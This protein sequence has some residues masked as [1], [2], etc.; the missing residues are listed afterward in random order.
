MF[1]P[2]LT[3]V[4]L[5]HTS[6]GDTDAR[7]QYCRAALNEGSSDVIL[8]IWRLTILPSDTPELQTALTRTSQRGDDDLNHLFIPDVTLRF[9]GK[10]PLHSTSGAAGITVADS[11]FQIHRRPAPKTGF[12]LLRPLAGPIRHNSFSTRHLPFHRS[13]GIGRV[14]V[15]WPCWLGNVCVLCCSCLSVS[16]VPHDLTLQPSFNAPH[17]TGRADCPHPALRPV[18][19]DGDSPYHLPMPWAPSLPTDP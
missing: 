6:C 5:H 2:R 11:R 18:S 1:K 3:A 19:H 14:D 10:S 4:G 9:Q 16:R 7:G 12:V 8:L 17:R 13:G 15:L